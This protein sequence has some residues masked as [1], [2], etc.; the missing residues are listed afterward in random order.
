MAFPSIS[1]LNATP[2]FDN[3]FAQ[4]SAPSNQFAFKL[5]STD[6]ELYIGGVNPEQFSDFIEFHPVL[7]ESG[8]WQIGEGAIH[9]GSETPVTG[10]Q[11]IIDSGT[12]IIYGPPESVKELYDSVPGAEIFDSKNGFYSFPCSSPPSVSFSWEEGRR[13]RISDDK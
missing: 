2:F 13:W 9:T 4:G 7:S 3:A 10:I 11:T 5:A 6:S 1:N 8:F 12:T